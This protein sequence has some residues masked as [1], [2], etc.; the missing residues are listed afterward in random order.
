MP[1]AWKVDAPSPA[2]PPLLLRL[3]CQLSARA[4]ERLVECVG[5]EHTEGARNP[6]CEHCLHDAT[7]CLR[8]NV[9]EVWRFSADNAAEC[10]NRIVSLLLCERFDYQGKF[11]TARTRHDGDTFLLDAV[12]AKLA[13]RALEQSRGDQVHSTGLLRWQCA[14]QKY[15]VLR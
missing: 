15:G 14:Q 6:A 12:A 4:I 9:I 13:E 7:C 5:C 10:D 11:E 1:G 8:R 3:Y 2:R